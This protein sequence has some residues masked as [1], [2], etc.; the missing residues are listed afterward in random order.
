MEIATY[1]EV[2]MEKPVHEG[3]GMFLFIL[4]LVIFF[5]LSLYLVLS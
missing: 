3:F 4:G 2:S 5:G 1:R